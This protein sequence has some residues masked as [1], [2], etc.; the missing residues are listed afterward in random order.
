MFDSPKGNLLDNNRFQAWEKSIICFSEYH[1][2]WILSVICLAALAIRFAYWIQDPV[3]PRDSIYYLHMLD[4]FSRNGDNSPGSFPPIPLWIWA[5]MKRNNLAPE[6]YGRL[7]NIV[8]DTFLILIVFKI[9]RHL[10]QKKFF[11]LLAGAMIAVHPELV[12][13]STS[14]LRESLMLLF[15]ALSILIF[16]QYFKKL[17][18]IALVGASFY[19]GTAFL[20]RYEAGEFL[21]WLVAG[22]WLLKWR[23]HIKLTL[24]LLHV[25]IGGCSFVLTIVAWELFMRLPIDYCLRGLLWRL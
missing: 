4:D 21:F 17:S 19:A 25:I 11:C 7:L 13:L 2:G 3:L 10:T 20:C 1:T 22:V 15:L 18:I 12:E 8:S 5:S 24:L 23:R 9:C 14:L 6:Y 16:L